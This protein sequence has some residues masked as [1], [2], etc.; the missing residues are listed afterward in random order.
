MLKSLPLGRV[1][2][3]AIFRSLE[4][5]GKGYPALGRSAHV[6]RKN[7]A[8]RPPLLFVGFFVDVNCGG[9]VASAPISWS[10]GFYHEVK[11]VQ[12]D[13]REI[14]LL[15][16]ERVTFTP[17]KSASAKPHQVGLYPLERLSCQ[18]QDSH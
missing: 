4:V 13:A 9:P 2:N 15:D 11:V 6:A 7:F 12:K 17:K 5:R 16:V 3:G 14:P 10:V 8:K 1:R 18:V